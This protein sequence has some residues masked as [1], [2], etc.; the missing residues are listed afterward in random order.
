LGDTVGKLAEGAP[1]FELVRFNQEDVP[2][3]PRKRKATLCL[4]S[5]L[6]PSPA[7]K[8]DNN[9]ICVDAG[10]ATL[11]TFK[12]GNGLVENSDFFAVAGQRVPAKVRY[13]VGGVLR[14][15]ITQTMTELTDATPNVLEAPPD[16]QVLSGCTTFRRAFGQI[17][18]Q[19]KSGDGGGV[20]NEPL[21]GVIGTNGRVQDAVVQRTDR[22]TLA[23]KSLQPF[24]SGIDASLVQRQPRP[25]WRQSCAPF[26]GKMSLN[27][28]TATT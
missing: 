16:A 23:P 12:S 11:V 24:S 26:S 21:R 19:P 6:I 8:T 22:P 1:A 3:S 18:P 10:A 7:K 17:M 15:E 20:S 2:S 27:S 13:S 9:E 25:G 4:A 14:I 28:E 5:N